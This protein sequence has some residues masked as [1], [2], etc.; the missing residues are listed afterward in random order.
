MF[1]K[2]SK[3]CV[4]LIHHH[5]ACHL[6]ENWNLIYTRIKFQILHIVFTVEAQSTFQNR[7]CLKYLKVERKRGFK[8]NI[9]ENGIFWC[10][11]TIFLMLWQR[12][13][14]SLQR[15]YETP[16]ISLQIDTKI[17][18]LLLPIFDCIIQCLYN[19]SLRLTL[20]RTL[21]ENLKL[22]YLISTIRFMP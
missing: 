17:A 2:H 5:L 12:S 9:S 21:L 10:S 20:L 7:P 22:I 8:H 11:V 4:S 16:Y 18:F 14:L 1:G 15:P 3:T 6:K 13:H 19:Q